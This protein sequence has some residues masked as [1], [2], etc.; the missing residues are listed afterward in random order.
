M[1]SRSNI[2][3]TIRVPASLTAAQR[4]SAGRK[5]VNLIRER[6]RDG[7][8]ATGKQFPG[9]SKA[10]ISSKDFKIAGKSSQ[11]NLT[12]TGDMLAE[13]EVLSTAPGS[14]TIGYP[15]DHPDADKV[16]GNT[17]G[18]F[19]Q[20]TGSAGKAR[21]FIGLPQSQIDIVVAEVRSETPGVDEGQQSV[22]EN[23][24]QQLGL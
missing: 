4:Q 8:S 3:T 12:Q 2:Q 14:I 16:E 24:L 20:P 23:I 1:A 11:P 13:L 15:T 17:I 6:T 19:G 22:V 10:Y 18:S 21:D 5:M 9:Y 7:I